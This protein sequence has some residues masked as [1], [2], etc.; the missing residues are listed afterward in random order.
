MQSSLLRN[1]DSFR[2]EKLQEHEL[3][4]IILTT[5]QRL[6]NITP[7]TKAGEHYNIILAKVLK[8][9]SDDTG[10]LIKKK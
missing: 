6:Q 9:T 3:R 1:S 10:D 7:N 2:M 4:K 8:K 5:V